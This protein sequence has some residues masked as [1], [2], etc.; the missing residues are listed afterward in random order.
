MRDPASVSI[1]ELIEIGF[2]ERASDIFVKCNS[3]PMMRQHAA[4]K[5]QNAE[6]A[7]DEG[8]G[9]GEIHGLVSGGVTHDKRLH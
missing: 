9:T 8:V 1:H 7:V 6:F 2:H 3:V 4:M 5:G